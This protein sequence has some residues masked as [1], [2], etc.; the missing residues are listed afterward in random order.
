MTQS[1]KPCV[2][3]IVDDDEGLRESLAR[4]IR[5]GGLIPKIYASPE[6]FV[7]E[8]GS[9][10]P[11]CILLDVTMP[12]T[13][14]L[15]VLR[16]LKTRGNAIPV[17][18]ISAHDDENTRARGREL[19][20]DCFMRKPLDGQALLDAIARLAQDQHGPQALVSV[21]TGSGR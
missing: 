3:Y 7:E 6:V 15:D 11:A 1:G 13:S 2:V 14:G 18:L 8:V 17:I 16:L 4:L 9:E 10:V 20:A 12:R 19:G 21:P 5:S